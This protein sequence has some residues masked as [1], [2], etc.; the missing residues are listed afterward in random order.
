MSKA[1]LLARIEKLTTMKNAL[2]AQIAEIDEEI[3]I[4]HRAIEAVERGW[5]GVPDTAALLEDLPE[6]RD[7]SP[8]STCRTMMEACRKLADLHGGIL[9]LTPA[10]K[11]IRSIGLSKARTNAGVSSTLH[12][13]LRKRPDEWTHEAPG[14][15]R[16]TV[17][18]TAERDSSD[19]GG[20]RRAD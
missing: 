8:I 17:P 20:E 9:R 5:S 11:A 16:R 15:W 13:Y 18:L 2:L 1:E 7:D 3:E 6:Q 12:G 14:V 19:T 10:A 4:F